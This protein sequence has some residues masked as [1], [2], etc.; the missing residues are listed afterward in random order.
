MFLKRI[1][2][3][4]FPYFLFQTPNIRHEKKNSYQAIIRILVRR[5]IHVSKKKMRQGVVNEDDLLEIKQDISSLR[6]GYQLSV[7]QLSL[8]PPF[9]AIVN[10]PRVY[11]NP[12]SSD[13]RKIGAAC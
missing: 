7:Q 11:L 1:F 5:Y 9:S 2:P 4:N 13:V 10:T 12:R 3:V 8:F 6:C